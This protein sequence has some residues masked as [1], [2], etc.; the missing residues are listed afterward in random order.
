MKAL[1]KSELDPKNEI[2]VLKGSRPQLE[3]AFADAGITD[4]KIVDHDY[5]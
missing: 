3:K 5:K 1:V 2:I 4:V